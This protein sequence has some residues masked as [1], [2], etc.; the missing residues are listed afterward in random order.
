MTWVLISVPISYVNELNRVAALMLS[1]DANC[2][3]LV[4]IFLRLHS[5]G[6]QLAQ[7]FW[8]LWLFP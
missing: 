7:I 6:V 1:T 4:A 8:G 5:A 2:S 3:A